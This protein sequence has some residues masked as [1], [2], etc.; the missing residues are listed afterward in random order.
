MYG[1]GTRFSGHIGFDGIGKIL[2]AVIAGVIVHRADVI[3]TYYLNLELFNRS[4]L[5]TNG[6]HEFSI[7]I[8]RTAL[9]PVMV[10]SEIKVFI[11]MIG[12]NIFKI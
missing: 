2:N 7:R 12:I 3:L 9:C 11:Q 10:A 1:H 5:K 4:R 6:T 8:I